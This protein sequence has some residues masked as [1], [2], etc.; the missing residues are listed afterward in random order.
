MHVLLPDS[1][2][3]HRRNFAALF[4]ALK[5]GGIPY[6]RETSRKRWWKAH[7]DYRPFAEALAPH[8]AALDGADLGRAEA[9][10][11]NLWSLAKGEFLCLA[12]ARPRWHEGAGPN[13]PEAVLA[14][15][16]EDED[17][18][19][20]LLLCLAAARDWALFW[21]GWLAA[22]PEITHALA[23]SGSYI[24]TRAL[25]AVARR[26]G[27]RTF[28]LESFFTGHEFY[29]EERAAPLSNG[30]LL[31][32][33][34]WYGRLTLPDDR[35]ALRAAAHG[36]LKGMRNKN[37]RAT[38]VP[39]A[40]F[41]RDGRPVVLIVGQVLNDFS[42]LETPLPEVSSLA[43]Y[44]DLIA[45]LLAETDCN[46]IFKAH[47]WERKRPNLRRAFTLEA[48][49]RFAATL[50]PERAA[51]LRLVEKDAI[52][53]LFPH[54]DHAVALCSQGL[55]E[56]CQAGLKPAQIGRAFFGGKGFTHDFA[57]PAPYVAA[58]AAGL[59]GR[60]SVEE[61]RLFE[62][63][64]V[65]A[66][67]VHLVRNDAAGALTVAARLREPDHLPACPPAV[68]PDAPGVPVRALL[69]EV[70]ENPVPWLRDARWWLRRRLGL[71]AGPGEPPRR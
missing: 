48:L 7:G 55:L 32:D 33:P 20:D 62:D 14:R 54:V 65:R 59:P 38:P 8:L 63:F 25:H 49:E 70:A 52:T 58:L 27:L 47:P 2:H 18:R 13:T 4:D 46:V 56:A 22:R 67:L 61:Y 24:Y 10:G 1:W 60:L 3:F 17:D 9:A 29:L 28:G 16:L 30:S 36:R 44:R 12:M 35:D 15:A 51:R 71:T 68:A 66:L 37:V 50:P 57:A 23:F 6:T 53:S 43:V 45:R 41:W 39:L 31:A 5:A 19:R 42:I 21:D 11:V 26:R 69:R 34:D 64:L 40:P